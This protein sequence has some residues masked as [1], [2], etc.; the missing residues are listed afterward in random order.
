MDYGRAN[1]VNMSKDF[2]SPPAKRAVAVGNFEASWCKH[3]MFASMVN[4]GPHW[5]LVGPID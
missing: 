1:W 4:E 5:M 3:K 2:K